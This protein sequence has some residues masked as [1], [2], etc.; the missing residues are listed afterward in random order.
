M[1]VAG[2]WRTASLACSAAPSTAVAADKTA[3]STAGAATPTAFSTVLRRVSS[4]AAFVLM[5]AIVAS[6]FRPSI[7]LI[8]FSRS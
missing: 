8:N 5:L 3:P 1:G 2:V 7:F 6:R 4:S